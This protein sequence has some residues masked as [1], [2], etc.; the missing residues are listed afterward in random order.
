MLNT[1]P[2]PTDKTVNVPSSTTTVGAI[3]GGILAATLAPH[4]SDPIGADAVSGAI[5]GLITWLFH[6]AHSKIGTPE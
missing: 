2:P 6:L 4:I 1:P 5:T 3:L